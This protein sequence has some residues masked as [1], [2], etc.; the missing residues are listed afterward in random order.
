[1]SFARTKMLYDR[2]GELGGQVTPAM[3]SFAAK[4]YHNTRRT[5][6]ASS[7]V[8]HGALIPPR[9]RSCFNPLRSKVTT[10]AND[11]SIHKTTC[12]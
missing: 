7:Q 12:N 6:R 3:A 10:A 8:T 9:G 1:M 2:V 4:R 11:L 5:D